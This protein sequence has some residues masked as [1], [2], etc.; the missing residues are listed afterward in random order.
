MAVP[1]WTCNPLSSVP[2]AAESVLAAQMR[3]NEPGV[4]GEDRTTV[5]TTSGDT[6][7]A[8]LCHGKAEQGESQAKDGS[9]L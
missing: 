7:A 4:C 8:N 6:P 1:P 2:A 9:A 3:R 5:V